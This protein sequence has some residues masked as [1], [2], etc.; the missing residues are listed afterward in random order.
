M[1]RKT[2]TT[3]LAAV[4]SLSFS[5][6]IHAEGPADSSSSQQALKAVDS[7]IKR[8]PKLEMYPCNDCHSE[9]DE[10]NATPRALEEEHQKMQI[11]YANEG[12]KRWC[13]SCHEE[14]NYMK[15]R[16]QSGQL[17]SFNESYRQ[18]GQCHSSQY[19]DWL[20]NAHGKR[21][22]SWKSPRQIYSC[23]QCHDAHDPAIKPLKAL[24]APPRPTNN[25]WR[26]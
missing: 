7:V 23:T 13:Q 14:K 20:K 5:W 4:L 3:F 16:L 22:G 17:V 8:T 24:K 6:H 12:D 10:F 19:K 15:L 26:F 2:L 1:T 18:C 21:T 11:H 25:F 9:P